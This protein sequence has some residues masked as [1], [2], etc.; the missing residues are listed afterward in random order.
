MADFLA[1]ALI[2][3]GSSFARG[4]DKEE[5]IARLGRII[6]SDW[7]GVYD[8]AGKDCSI[9]VFDVT[10]YDNLYWDARGVHVNNGEQAD[11]TLDRL[12]LRKITLPS[13]K[14]SRKRFG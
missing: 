7:G 12:E 8:V 1:V 14:Q 9:N 10:G 5:V 6:V 2:G 11:I 4:E 13:R 3:A